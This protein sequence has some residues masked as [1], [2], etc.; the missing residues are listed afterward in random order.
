ME[1]GAVNR[2]IKHAKTLKGTKKLHFISDLGLDEEDGK[3]RT[4]LIRN[5]SCHQCEHCWR[6]DYDKCTNLKIAGGARMEQIEALAPVSIPLTRSA[7]AIEGKEKAFIIAAST[8][9]VR[10][11][12][13]HNEFKTL[14]NAIAVELDT[15]NESWMVGMPLL[16]DGCESAC[17]AATKGVDANDNWM[18]GVEPKDAVVW[19]RKLEP[20]THGGSIFNLTDQYLYCFAEDVR[21]VGIEMR[22]EKV[23]TSA[24]RSNSNSDSVRWVMCS[25]DRASILSR[26]PMDEDQPLRGKVNAM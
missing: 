1:I 18:G 14:T 9:E 8:I 17:R 22:E 15:G 2:R 21:H 5:Y 24:R 3:Y 11:D 23:R 6:Q 4:I 26:M 12:K 25:G 16:S 13:A 10:V 20:T 7:L 19:L